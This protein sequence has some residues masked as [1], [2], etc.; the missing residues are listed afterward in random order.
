MPSGLPPSL[1]S[2]PRPAMLVAIVT[3]PLRPAW[4]I[5]SPSRLGGS[6]AA[7]AAASAAPPRGPPPGQV[8]GDHLRDLDRNRPDQDR[9]AGLVSRLNLVEDGVPLAVLGLVDL[10]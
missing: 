8:A 1:M 9:L 4:A 10:V 2:T 6:G 5:V 7:L 3:A